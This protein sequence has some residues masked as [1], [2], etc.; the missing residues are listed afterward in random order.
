MNISGIDVKKGESCSKTAYG[1]AKKT[2]LNNEFA[3]V[4]EIDFGFSN[5]IEINGLKFGISSDGI[6]TKIEIA[7]RISKYDTLG[8]DLIAMVCDDLVSNGFIPVSIS[9][10]LDVDYLDENIVN[11]L[12][13]GLYNATNE[14]NISIS[15]GEIAELGN[16]ISGFGDKMHFNWCATGMGILHKSLNTPIDGKNIKPNNIIISLQSN[17]FRSNGFSLLRKILFENFGNNWHNEKY[18]D[19]TYGELLLNPS[20]LYSNIIKEILDNNILI[21][22]IAHITGGGIFDNLLRILKINSL[23]ANLNNVLT[24][25][26]FM[27]HIQN[28]G[29]IDNYKAYQLWNMN[30][31]MLLIINESDLNQTIEI[32]NQKRIGF[33]IAGVITNERTVNIKTKNEILKYT[34]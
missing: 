13:W 20:I 34:Y 12:F 19:K 26:D 24:P 30:N 28:M 14:I 31:G 29:N 32:L 22:G 18:N 7:E 16:R 3:K 15:G 23:G 21:N 27:L 17:N 6:G 8:F 4:K 11:D 9:N 5:L 33:S 25:A 1:Y 2:F 10:I